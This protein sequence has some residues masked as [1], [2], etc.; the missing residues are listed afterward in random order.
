MKCESYGHLRIF[1]PIQ[2]TF[3]TFLFSACYNTDSKWTVFEIVLSKRE[4]HLYKKIIQILGIYI[5]K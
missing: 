2:L 3:K 4:N 5:W 1:I